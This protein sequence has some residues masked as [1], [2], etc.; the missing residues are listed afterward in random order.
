[1][2]ILTLP[3]SLHVMFWIIWPVPM[4]MVLHINV[5]TQ[6]EN[7]NYHFYLFE[8]IA[9]HIILTQLDAHLFSITLGCQA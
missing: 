3:S 2:N 4:L 6:F 5:V 7:I 8:F 9:W 1:M